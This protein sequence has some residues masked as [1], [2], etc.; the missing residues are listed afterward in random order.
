L[1]GLEDSVLSLPSLRNDRRLPIVLS[2][3]ELRRLFFAPQQLKH[4]VLLPLIY[5]AGMRV[6][7]VCNPKI[8]AIDSDRMQVRIVQSKGKCDRHVPLGRIPRTIYPQNSH[9]NSPHKVHRS[10]SN[11][12]SIQGL[13]AERNQQNNAFERNRVLVPI[14]SALIACGVCS[15]APL[16]HPHFQKQTQGTEPR[17]DAFW[18]GFV[19]GFEDRLGRNCRDKTGHP[20]QYLCS[21]RRALE[22]IAVLNGPREPPHK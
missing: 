6:G 5:S 3:E 12:L 22:V 7:E 21:L 9:L 11:N 1:Y 19:G 10:Q 18:N 2:Y 17:Q 4:R 20:T 14:L 15:P 16:R 13:Q 8:S